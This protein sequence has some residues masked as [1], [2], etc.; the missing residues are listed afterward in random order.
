MF[1]LGCILR[2][3]ILRWKFAYKRLVGKY[4][5]EQQLLES[6]GSR[7]G[8]KEILYCETVVPEASATPTWSSGAGGHFSC[9]KSRKG[10]QDF[11]S[12]S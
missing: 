4:K 7:T 8:Q 5:R 12:L 10:N 2:E 9:S 11:V 3:N 1:V 6:K